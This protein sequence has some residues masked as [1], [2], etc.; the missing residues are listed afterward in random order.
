[1][2]DIRKEK[3]QII[4]AVIGLVLIIIAVLVAIFFRD[5]TTTFNQEVIDAQSKELLLKANP[6]I[7]DASKQINIQSP[8]FIEFSSQTI[9]LNNGWQVKEG[10]LG[11]EV[12]GIICKSQTKDCP[13]FIIAKDEFEFY[14]SNQSIN[15]NR[16]NIEGI[17]YKDGYIV[18]TF[19]GD[20]NFSYYNSLVY[21]PDVSAQGGVVS[22]EILTELK[23][24][25]NSSLCLTSGLLSTDKEENNKYLDAFKELLISI[26]EV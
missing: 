24:C 20:L 6:Q 12:F 10:R 8:G 2:L 25:I 13:V 21:V 15:Y 7:I 4:I 9:L 26:N 17:T 16:K 3:D 18:T 5:F 1:M 14:L 19:A 23:G 22:S 11:K